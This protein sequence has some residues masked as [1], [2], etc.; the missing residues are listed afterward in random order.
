MIL[1]TAAFVLLSYVG[2]Y[3]LVK[4]DAKEQIELYKEAFAKG[5]ETKHER[6]PFSPEEAIFESESSIEEE[7][8]VATFPYRRERGD[9]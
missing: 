6:P 2:I 1:L 8:E 7:E 4:A 5:Y 3:L 9:D